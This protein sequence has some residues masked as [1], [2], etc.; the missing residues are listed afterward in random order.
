MLEFQRLFS[1]DDW[2]NRET[3]ASVVRAARAPDKTRTVL[4]HIIGTEWEWYA[5]I[6]GG[7]SH[8]PVWPA[9][10][11]AECIAESSRL[12]ASWRELLASLD[13]AGLSRPVTY[14]NSKGEPW[15]SPVGDIL[16]HVALH[17]SYHR[18]QIATLL[19]D[20]GHE[21]AYTDFIHAA[22]QGKL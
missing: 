9:L 16:M 2:A 11:P 20:S 10:D 18:G 22:R 17:S 14:K 3:A 8:M 6:H 13:A 1:H 4:A 19:R 7:K 21:P 5:R 15:T 12:L